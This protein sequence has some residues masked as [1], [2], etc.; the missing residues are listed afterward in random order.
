MSEAP[1][2]LTEENIST[3]TRVAS[4]PAAQKAAKSAAKNPAVQKAAQ[5]HVE[6]EAP[7]WTSDD[8]Q[9]DL[10]KGKKAD[11]APKHSPPPPPPASAKKAP[12]DTDM[13]DI[14]PAVMKEMQRYHLALRILYMGSA[15]FLCTA[16]ALSLSNQSDLGLAFF[17]FY[18]FFFSALIC[19]FEV[20]LTVRRSFFL[21]SYISSGLTKGLLLLLILG[22]LKTHR[23]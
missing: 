21:S 7:G 10:E 22:H 19:C 2:W 20:A 17:A 14:D 23:G 9:S 3:A 1:S 18:V 15:V 5:A 6:K 11:K 12:V 8:V 16:A 4:N 13:S